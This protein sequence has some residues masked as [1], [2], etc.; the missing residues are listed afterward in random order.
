MGKL[1]AVGC[2]DLWTCG[3][4]KLPES[5]KKDSIHTVCCV[6]NTH[7]SKTTQTTRNARGDVKNG[8]KNTPKP[9]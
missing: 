5:P 7:V 9:L 4:L 3:M 2:L 6:N 8:N 1:G